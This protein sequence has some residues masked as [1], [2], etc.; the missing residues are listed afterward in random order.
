MIHVLRGYNL[1]SSGVWRWSNVRRLYVLWAFSTKRTPLSICYTK[2]KKISEVGRH[3]SSSSSGW[4]ASALIASSCAACQY[5]VSGVLGYVAIWFN[6]VWIKQAGTIRNFCQPGCFRLFVRILVLVY[7]LSKQS[8]MIPC[9]CSATPHLEFCLLSGSLSLNI[10]LVANLQ[11]RIEPVMAA[12]FSGGGLLV[13]YDVMFCQDLA[14][15]FHNHTGSHAVRL[16]YISWNRPTMRPVSSEIRPHSSSRCRR[17]LSG[18]QWTER[19]RGQHGQHGFLSWSVWVSFISR[20]FEWAV[21]V[22]NVSPVTDACSGKLLMLHKK[23]Q[24]WNA[25][26]A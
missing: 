5:H 6:F 26:F 2:S 23:E 4:F 20:G 17:E 18:F 1:L 13:Q 21:I 3:Y 14:P 9:C 10:L 24:P 15:A 22:Y 16:W 11:V 19:Q 12:M 7:S 25:V 8:S